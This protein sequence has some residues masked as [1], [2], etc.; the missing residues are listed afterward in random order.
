VQGYIIV[1]FF[2]TEYTDYTE[3][4]TG[5]YRADYDNF[6][7]TLKFLIKSRNQ[8]FSGARANPKKV[9][10]DSY[11]YGWFVGIAAMGLVGKQ[12]QP[13]GFLGGFLC[14]LSFP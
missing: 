2:T 3:K 10:T 4:N 12:S 14:L 13:V 6:P 9:R 11:R 5:L 7:H 1:P 8:C